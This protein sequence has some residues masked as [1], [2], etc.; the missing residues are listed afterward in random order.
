MS[1]KGEIWYLDTRMV[2]HTGRGEKQDGPGN[3]MT[4]FRRS[5]LDH[6]DGAEAAEKWEAG[7][8]SGTDDTEGRTPRHRLI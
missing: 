8:R 4:F 3:P 2:K 5:R 7:D 6:G 1:K